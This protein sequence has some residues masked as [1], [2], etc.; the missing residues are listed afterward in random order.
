M[1]EKYFYFSLC[2]QYHKYLEV[3]IIEKLPVP[4]GL[5]RYGVAPDHQNVKVASYLWDFISG[6]QHSLGLHLYVQNV[7][8]QFTSVAKSD[9]CRFIG[10]VAV[11]HH[12][13]VAALR[14]FYNGIVFVSYRDESTWY[15]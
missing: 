14:Q 15:Q 1:L 2:Y 12:I 11:G 3:D 9:R 13:S 6:K 8:S 4:F 5:V 7:T 10:N